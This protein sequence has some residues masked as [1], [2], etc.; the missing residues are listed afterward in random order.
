MD[1]TITGTVVPRSTNTSNSTTTASAK[2][3]NAAS[4]K[5]IQDRFLTL[6]VT[7]MRNQDPLNPMDNSQMTSQL[8]Q[9]STVSGIEGLNTTMQSLAAQFAGL[10]AMQAAGMSGR[11]VMVS[12]NQVKLGADGVGRGGVRIDD[13]VDQMRVVIKD[14][15]GATV[16]TLELGSS[17]AGVRHFEW[18]GRDDRGVKMNT[19][20]YR[21]S[22]EASSG[23][24]PAVAEALTRMRVEGVLQGE[25]GAR[26][27]LGTTGT[28]PVS[29]VVEII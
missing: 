24:K 22:V 6:L 1:N 8:S 21:F 9:I 10:Q 7:Q 18:D 14:G 27:N 12:G 16:R 13:A 29:D 19:G 25:G 17:S 28:R 20:D 5:E 2:N 23:G 4:A 15:A 26:L 3:A 11:D